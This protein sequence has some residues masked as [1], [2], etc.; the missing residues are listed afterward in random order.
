MSGRRIDDHKSFCGS[1]GE[2]PLPTGNKM[3][4]FKTAEGVGHVGTMY[5]DTSEDIH[6]DQM[7]GESKA[8]SQKMKPGY[9]H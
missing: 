6:R 8:T 4:S 9:R 2:Y 3:K 7:A 5:P 1:S